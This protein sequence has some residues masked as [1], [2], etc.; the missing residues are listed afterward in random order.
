VR[1]IGILRDFK[2]LLQV[3]VVD[4]S[5]KPLKLTRIKPFFSA[6]RSNGLKKF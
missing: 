5:I 1:I 4:I 6:S 3:E 2:P